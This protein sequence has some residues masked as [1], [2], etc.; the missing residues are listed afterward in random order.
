MT[1]DSVL[2]VYNWLKENDITIWIDGGRPVDAL[3]AKQTRENEDLD[4]A[5]VYIS[6][7]WN[8]LK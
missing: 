3:I 6:N 7:V 4:I 1:A 5:V 2:N 8:N